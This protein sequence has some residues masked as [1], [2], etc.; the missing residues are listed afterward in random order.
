MDDSLVD[1]RAVGEFRKARRRA[2]WWERYQELRRKPAHLLPFDA[3][4]GALR[5]YSRRA[6]GLQQVPVDLI[7]GSVDRSDDFTRNYLPR[8]NY[9][10]ARWARVFSHVM[11]Q[12]F[13]PIR[14]N[15]VGDVYFVEDGNHRLS[16]LRA[17]D[18]A[19]VEAQVT[20]FPCRVPLSR[21]L[22]LSDLPRKAAYLD[23][24]E[25]TDLDQTRPGVQI[26]LSEPT[27]YRTLEEHIAG[28]AY[29]LEFRDG[30]P[31]SVCRAAASW[32][33]LVYVPAVKLI[34][35]ARL[36]RDFPNATEADLYVELMEYHRKLARELERPVRLEDAIEHY[37]MTSTRPLRRR[38]WYW[39]T[40]RRARF[41]PISGPAQPAGRGR[42]HSWDWL[43]TRRADSDQSG[44]G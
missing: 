5:L 10:E 43:P 4:T 8:R 42:R 20:E 3:V 30:R 16:V 18:V 29:W 38:L 32:H 12:G 11:E 34:R 7:I 27:A 36:D 35:G 39:A 2:M 40:R 25:Q 41:D 9:L 6:V 13:Q 14:L 21:E 19:T 37:R 33:D 23:F 31:V 44:D 22:T 1:L 26:E 17:M 28:H 15:R 24:L